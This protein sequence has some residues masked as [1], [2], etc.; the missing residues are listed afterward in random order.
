MLDD[1]EQALPQLVAHAGSAPV[2]VLL[3]RRLLLADGDQERARDEEA[4]AVP[5][6]GVRRR[7][8]LDQS[9][10]DCRARE[11]PGRAR[12]LEL[13]VPVDEV[14]AIDE[15]RQVRLVRDVEEDGQ[16]AREEA[17]HEQLGHGQVALEVDDRHRQEQKAAS[18]VA[19]DQ[20]AAAR[21]PVDPHACRQRE[22]EEGQELDRAERGDRERRRVQQLDRDDRQRQLRDRRAELTDRLARPHLHEVAVAPER[23]RRST[24]RRISVAQMPPVSELGVAAGPVGGAEVVHQ[25]LRAALE[26]LHVFLREPRAN[27]AET[28]HDR[29]QLDL[30][31]G[32]PEGDGRD[33]PAVCGILGLVEEEPRRAAVELLRHRAHLAGADDADQAGRLEHLEVMADGALRDGEL[34][35][36]APASN[37]PGRAAAAPAGCGKDRPAPAAA[38]GSETIIVSSAS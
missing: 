34:V 10:C 18:D 33:R 31:R 13:R 37:A 5:H 35:P 26:P 28:G 29:C 9:A 36:R 17:D 14:L 16:D 6:D 23:A 8:E 1:I 27:E 32:L 38:H 3:E 19:D 30:A 15:R 20:H 7:Q 22:E 24:H 4:H 2:L 25:L 21:Q 12:H 11:L